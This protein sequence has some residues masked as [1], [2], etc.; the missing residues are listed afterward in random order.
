MLNE[1]RTK[2]KKTWE[3]TM[4]GSR[5]PKWKFC[6][7]IATPIDWVEFWS[8]RCALKALSV[9]LALPLLRPAAVILTLACILALAPA[10]QARTCSG[11]GDVIGSFGWLGSRSAEFVPDPIVTPAAP[12]AGS[13]TLIGGLAAGAANIFAFA[14]VGR[15]FLDG[16]GGLFAASTPGGPVVSAGSYNVNSDCTISATITDAFAIPGVPG[17]IPVAARVTFEG[18]VVGGGNEVDLTQTGTVSGT[19]LTLKKTQQSCTINGL[20][21]A[22]GIT[23]TGVAPTPTTTTT[24]PGLTTPSDL[25]PFTILGRFVADGA[26]NL[27]EDATAL[28]SPLVNRE[29]TGTYNVNSDCTGTALLVTADGQKRNANLVIVNVGSDL[30]NGPQ[31]LEFAFSDPGVVGS[32]SAQQQ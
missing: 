10:L 26:G 4:N 14:S 29:V 20:F 23:A 24:P 1:T 11:N 19:I 12:I 27:V 28:Q 7:C 15:L 22:F 31:A 17:T 8:Q 32:G 25:A 3:A 13:A 16:N 30:S 2:Q 6:R 9:I 21:S 5:M 18:V